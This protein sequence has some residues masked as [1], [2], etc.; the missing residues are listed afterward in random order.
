MTVALLL[1][2]FTTPGT[3]EGASGSN[4]PAGPG[5]NAGDNSLGGSPQAATS[6]DLEEIGLYT[7][8]PLVLGFIQNTSYDD[9]E[10][11]GMNGT[12]R[13]LV[14]ANGSVVRDDNRYS[15]DNVEYYANFLGR[16]TPF[17]VPGQVKHL[18]STP[19]W[20]SENNAFRRYVNGTGTVID[21]DLPIDVNTV[22]LLIL[23]KYV[24]NESQE[25]NAR[26]MMDQIWNAI[27]A[28]MWDE[29]LDLFLPENR[30][31]PNADTIDVASVLWG[32]IA[33]CTMHQNEFFKND[34]A[35]VEAKKAMWA[36]NQTSP[37]SGYD[38]TNGGFYWTMDKDGNLLNTRKTLKTNSLGIM[39]LARLYVS[40]GL[41]QS[42]LAGAEEVFDFVY[43]HMYND[44]WFSDGKVF[45][46]KTSEDG[47][48]PWGTENPAV[49]LE[50]SSYLMMALDDLYWVT[51]NQTYLDLAL[52][53]SDTVE[54]FL[55]DPENGAY[56]HS[57][58]F[59]SNNTDKDVAAL[60][61]L[62][63]AYNRL[64]DTGKYSG[65]QAWSNQT[66][67][68]KGEQATVNVTMM[69]NLT[70]TYN[71]QHIS[72]ASWFTN[73]SIGGATTR[74]IVRYPNGTVLLT[75]E[76]STNVNGTDSVEFDIPV[77]AP[78]GN[79]SI[80]IYVNRTGFL[81][82]SKKLEVTF[83]GGL[84][85]DQEL[86]VDP[87][88][89]GEKATLTVKI[90]SSREDLFYSNASLYG[91][92]VYTDYKLQTIEN[93][94]TTEFTLDVNVKTDAPTGYGKVYLELY[95]DSLLYLSE[96]FY[97]EIDPAIQVGVV[98][99]PQHLV[100]GEVETVEV[101]VKNLRS[102]DQESVAVEITS[103]SFLT[104]VSYGSIDAGQLT[105][106]SI[107]V[108]ANRV[109]PT[110][111]F[112]Y[113]VNV[114]RGNV[115]YFLNMYSLTVELPLEV[116]SIKTTDRVLQDQEV[117]VALDV[118]N[119]MQTPQQIQLLID[120]RPTSKN[121]TLVPG[122]NNLLVAVPPLNRHPWDYGEKPVL[123]E[124]VFNGEVYTRDQF[125][126]TLEFAVRNIIW[127]IIVP[128]GLPFVIFT[129]YKHWEVKNEIF[130]RRRE[131]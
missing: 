98:N 83:W 8:H 50:D 9:K 75:R 41:N 109:L 1:S 43:E 46:N 103:D 16:Y 59:H 113:S 87:V 48:I 125:T 54:N 112:T 95:N 88:V 21:Y 4:S 97:I 89:Q 122:E 108:V 77:D 82:K 121:Y 80:S 71:Y 68:V 40:S 57:I 18:Q 25:V 86:K 73:S 5:G 42:Y 12:V 78:V 96:F 123:V 60:G 17:A 3:R 99:I 44:S 2:S 110:G 11:Y 91:D 129:G 24:T 66:K 10:D 79:Y 69:Y 32:I 116:E 105:M 120:G 114:T 111:N 94:T 70:R 118:R 85:L 131:D 14:D 62:Y 35:L 67:Y 64:S 119:N 90:K 23:D 55:W 65:I 37:A 36:L 104:K 49:T 30:T 53:V 61:L 29:D 74:Y 31:L 52:N 115:S 63:H 56:N 101:Y 39:A 100:N 117:Y 20:D 28:T 130:T 127:G 102:T 22:V 26:T 6:D 19:L 27:N 76:G 81:P 92:Y 47:T 126:V 72:G 7:H 38:R 33:A 58:G 107:P 51:G 45:V 106:I 34:S 93:E 15:L 124:L 128:L 84:E 13:H